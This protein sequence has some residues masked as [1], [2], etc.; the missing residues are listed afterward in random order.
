MIKIQHMYWKYFL[1]GCLV[2]AFIINDIISGL[3][4]QW[5]IVPALLNAL[6]FPFAMHFTITIARRLPG[7]SL[8]SHIEKMPV[9]GSSG[10]YALF[11]FA[12]SVL[13]MPLALLYFC[14][15]LIGK[16]AAK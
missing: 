16:R 14:C 8:W 3:W 4:P 11:W 5:L 7:K 1:I 15:L 6:L 9:Y 13:T 10:L 2:P 12:V